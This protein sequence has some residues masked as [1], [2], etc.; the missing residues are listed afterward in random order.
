MTCPRKGERVRVLWREPGSTT[1]LV[2]TPAVVWKAMP[3]RGLFIAE[4]EDFRH[5]FDVEGRD[6]RRP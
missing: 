2:W 5:T 3:S 1:S 6:W 4:G